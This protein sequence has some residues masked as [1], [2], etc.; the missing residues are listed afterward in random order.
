MLTGDPNA[1]L[2]N[3]KA[4]RIKT[5]FPYFLVIGGELPVVHSGWHS[6]IERKTKLEI[7][8]KMV[9]RAQLGLQSRRKSKV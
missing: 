1:G 9:W 2:P 3:Y 4:F 7:V 6:G 5:K 8:C